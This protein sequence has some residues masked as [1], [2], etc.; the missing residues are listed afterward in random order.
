M[1]GHEKQIGTHD[2]HPLKQLMREC[3][4]RAR[5]TREEIRE[6]MNEN[7][8]KFHG[9]YSITRK[10]ELHSREIKEVIRISYAGEKKEEYAKN[11][12][13]YRK[14]FID[15]EVKNVFATGK[16]TTPMI[17]CSRGF[18]HCRLWEAMINNNMVEA[19]RPRC[20][21]VETWEH[22]IKCEKTIE[23]RIKFIKE[24]V[25]EL[26]RNKPKEV[27]VEETM[28]FAEDILRYLENEEDEECE[29]DQQRAGMKELFRGYMVI[30]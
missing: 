9:S 17:K 3:D 28:S 12:C 24:L 18:N 11:K 16:A 10:G 29:M 27:H 30:D 26:A 4:M 13:G 8:I 5:K 25:I 23:L 14:D 2:Q 21:E 15:M 19:M 20:E 6:K 22:V 7:N 1:K